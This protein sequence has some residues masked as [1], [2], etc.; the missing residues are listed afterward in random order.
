MTWIL[1]HILAVG[2]GISLGLIGGGGSVLALPTLVYVMGIP[3]KSAVAM[4]L[5]IVGTVSL[6]GVIPHWRQRNVNLKTAF[7]FGSATMLGAFA[8]AKIANLPFVTDT[9]Q[10]LLFAVMMFLAAGLMIKRSVKTATKKPTE[11]PTLELYPQP[12]CKHCWLWLVSEGLGV[13]VLTGLVGVGGGFAIIPALVILGN[14]P[15]KEAIGTSLLI[16]AA[17]AASG[18]LGYWGEVDL[19]GKVIGSFIIAASVGSLLGAYLSKYIDSKKLQKYF[20]YFLLG[21]AAFILLQNRHVFQDFRLKKAI[22]WHNSD[23]QEPYL[24]ITQNR[25]KISTSS[26]Y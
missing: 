13:G 2:I 25:K 10:M 1:G 12:I 20:G 11:K 21:I 9:L 7:I 15:M 5:V 24:T 8:G 17:N 19:D 4:T 3:T 26:L 18:F 14:L 16:I 6:I 22:D 23:H